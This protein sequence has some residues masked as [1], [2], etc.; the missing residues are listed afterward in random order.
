MAKV[1]SLESVG[2]PKISTGNCGGNF[3]FLQKQKKMR[4]KQLS[5]L[6]INQNIIQL[7]EDGEKNRNEPFE[8]KINTTTFPTKIFCK[9]CRRNVLELFIPLIVGKIQ[10]RTQTVGFNKMM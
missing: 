4:L 6:L 2:L 7:E 9:V 3:S 1:D 10:N 5:H 8:E